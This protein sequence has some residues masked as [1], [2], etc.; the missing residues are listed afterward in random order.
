M[1]FLANEILE[2]KIM[3]YFTKSKYLMLHNFSIFPFEINE[4]NRNRK[5]YTSY[6]PDISKYFQL[7]I[8]VQ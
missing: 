2:I 4:K 6:S 3:N 1:L 5:A 7:Y 8:H